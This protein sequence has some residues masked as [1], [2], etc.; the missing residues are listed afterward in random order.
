MPYAP[1]VQYFL[2]TRQYREL[3]RHDSAVV[4]RALGLTVDQVEAALRLSVA[5]DLVRFDG[6]KYSL[7]HS[8]IEY[9]SADRAAVIAYFR[10][11][12]S[13]AL[14][15][16][17]ETPRPPDGTKVSG[18][19]VFACSRE[20]ASRITTKLRETYL[21]VARIIDEDGERK[22]ERD[23]VRVLVL[24]HFDPADCG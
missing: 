11:W 3:R 7:N 16:M 8:G 4:A 20:A 5:T 1:A 9:K 22:E 17:T 2:L 14:A 13:R 19:R 6:R 21:E 18:V 23:F 12:T 15:S 24:H 10:H